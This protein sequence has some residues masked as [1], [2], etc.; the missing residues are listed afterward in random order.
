MGRSFES[1]RAHHELI[2][3]KNGTG[4]V[5]EATAD[6]SYG[7]GLKAAAQHV[8]V[9]AYAPACLG[10]IERPREVGVHVLTLQAVEVG[11]N[12]A[13]IPHGG[14]AL[15]DQNPRKRILRI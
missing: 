2:F 4:A 14:S 11:S 5:L 1:C 10:F 13:L 3:S 15:G 8:I 6:S 9:R 12:A 7:P